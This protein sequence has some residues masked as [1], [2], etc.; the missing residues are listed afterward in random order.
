MKRVDT[1]LGAAL[2]SLSAAAKLM[3]DGYFVVWGARLQ[4]WY[5]ADMTDPNLL[6][7]VLGEVQRLCLDVEDHERSEV[8]EA[9]HELLGHLVALANAMHAEKARS[10]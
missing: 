3:N 1:A 4:C 5:A 8:S 6:A 2:K 10:L 7:Y 9:A